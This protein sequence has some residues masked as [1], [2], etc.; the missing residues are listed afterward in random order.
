MANIIT[1]QM[2]GQMLNLGHWSTDGLIY[3][4][5]TIEAGNAVDDSLY[6]NHG[7]F[8]NPPTWVGDALLFDGNDD[9]ITVTHADILNISSPATI[10]VWIKFTSS[11]STV[12]LEKNGNSGF[13]IQPFSSGNLICNWGGVTGSDGLQTS[14]EYDDGQWH[15]IAFVFR[16][17]AIDGS[18]FVD[19]VD[20][21][22]P[23]SLGQG[24]PAYGSNTPM[25]IGSRNGSFV[26][27]GSMKDISI[28]NRALS[29]S[30]IQALFI[31]PDLPMQQDPIWLR[32]PSAVGV[33]IPV[34]IHHYKQAGGL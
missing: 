1:P 20:D 31:N 27:N 32:L 8:T 14:K 11:D 24:T 29:A 4:F 5:R 18:V 19:V 30:E 6:N 25:F 16:G 13:S 34:M 7:V 10:I 21:T 2:F 26:F 3:Y 28:Y 9:L 33:T 15:Q 22:N 17:T 23:A 12:I